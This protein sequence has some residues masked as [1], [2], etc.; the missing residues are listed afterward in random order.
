M[1]FIISATGRTLLNISVLQ[2]FFRLT[3]CKQLAFSSFRELY[4]AA[5]GGTNPLFENFSAPLAVSS[6]FIVPCPLPLQ[7]TMTLIVPKY[8]ISDTYFN[9]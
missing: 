8:N 7:L 1:A 6:M 2:G 4:N 5:L 3:G 9:R